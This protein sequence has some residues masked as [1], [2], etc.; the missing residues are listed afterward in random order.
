MR[1]NT[2]NS[3]LAVMI[4]ALLVAAR[5]E[6]SIQK[7]E[8]ARPAERALAGGEVH[9]REIAI[10]EG[11]FLRVTVNQ[12]G[13]DVVLR[14]IDPSGA[15]AL[16]MDS[17]NNTQGPEVA[18]T[19]ASRGGN[20]VIE[21]RSLVDTAPKGR[22]E[23]RIEPPRS[24]NPADREWLEAQIAYLEGRR[25]NTLETAD[26]RRQAL[27][28]FEK[29]AR[30][31]HGLDDRV[32]EGHALGYIA[33]V[34][35][36]LGQMQQALEAYNR[37]SALQESGPAGVE[38]T[39]TLYNTG[40]V[41]DEMGEPRKALDYYERAIARQREMGDSYAEAETLG[42]MGVSFFSLGEIS[43]ALDHYNRALAFWSGN[44]IRDREALAFNNLGA[45]YRELG[46][47][48][49]AL[50]H[51]SRTL[52]IY[53]SLK[54]REGEAEALNN[55]GHINGLLGERRRALDY[56]RQA[57]L[58]WR[59][60]GDRRREAI[61][62][63]NIGLAYVAL[64]EPAMA[65]ENLELS[66]KYH[67]EVGNR[68][69]EAATLEKL[70]E[71]LASTGDAAGALENYNASLG[72]RRSL[73]LRGGEA[74]VL[75]G[76]GMLRLKGGDP[77]AALESLR[78]SLDI[79]RALEDKRG[80]ARALYGMARAHR[81]QGRAADARAAVEEAITQAESVR[82]GAGSEQ[83]KA[84]FLASVRQYYELDIDVLMRLARENPA[85]GFVEL[86]LRAA[87]RARARSLI[88]QLAESRADIRQGV[89]P[90]LLERERELGAQI[91][92]RARR[93]LELLS[94]NSP[95]SRLAALNSEI[96]ALEDQYQQAQLATRRS[97]PRYAAITQPRPLTAAEIRQQVIDG[98][99]MLLEYSLGAERSHL[100]AVTGGGVTAFELPN[101][102]RIRAVA[103]RVYRL[104]TARTERVPGESA[105]RRRARI[106]RADAGLPREVAELGQMVLSPVARLLGNR[107]LIVVP[108]GALQ[109][110]PFSILPKTV[111]GRPLIEEHE[112]VTLPSASTLAIL[113]R[114]TAGRTPAPRMLA[115]FADPVFDSSDS[116]VFPARQGRPAT[117]G[118]GTREIVHG[119]EK[120]SL[121]P[122][123]FAIRRL[124][125][126][127]LEAERILSTSP[128]NDNLELLDF[129]ASRE[130]AMGE[131]TGLYRYIHFATHGLLDN[132]HPGLSSLVLSLVDERGSPLDGFLRAHE[133]YNLRLPAELV[134][135]SACQT[136]LGSEI[137]G[138]GLVGLTR[139]FMYAGASR[140]V[141]SLWSVNDRATSE[142]MTLFYR[143]MLTEKQRP[144]EALRSSQIEMLRAKR[145]SSPFYWA[146]F[147]LQGDSN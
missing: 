114:E 41:Y 88:E 101:R 111:G 121:K 134:V 96:A 103:T 95:D 109:Y 98:D 90:A 66:L 57:L 129:K 116:R 30:I 35:R 94:Q 8:A 118:P 11:Q 120:A 141:V 39:Y 5:P 22:Y 20:C 14:L 87:E 56:Y 117:T 59:A 97:S 79:C 104:L 89:D 60:S 74:S 65:R 58:L 7:P 54:N 47:S 62:L 10:G 126:T 34:S 69:A 1:A 125:F 4:A 147:V 128:G 72:M 44:S 86:A 67:R 143:K 91:N 71:L 68:Q 75:A 73:G 55:I 19:I 49:K 3:A 9:R 102:D 24:P 6:A 108:D 78:Q 119:T 123:N 38:K 115:V 13:I 122:R 15:V 83:L 146:A 144:S 36:D 112:I 52:T 84:T 131:Q 81:D 2:K 46:E 92:A 45:V 63:S 26:S 64:G 28:Q 51:Y 27:A 110:I 33:S 16:D 135:L 106:A 18:A 40:L 105:A 70:G 23:L 25:L 127:R 136:G 113:R 43:Q 138:E 80:E 76:I 85:G 82:A 32:M 107:K 100:W 133:I 139:A 132:D 142:L 50:E 124:P 48:Q 42:S 99:S 12:A 53:R 140:V 29:A 61:A 145:W 130:S 17:L 37:A 31:W 137:D 93:K 77:V 21:V